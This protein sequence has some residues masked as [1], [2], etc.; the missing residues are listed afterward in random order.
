MAK[1]NGVSKGTLIAIN[2]VWVILGLSIALTIKNAYHLNFW[3]YLCI[4]VP[5]LIIGQTLIKK[6]IKVNE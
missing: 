6:F 5:F 3:V 4:T 1:K 2:S